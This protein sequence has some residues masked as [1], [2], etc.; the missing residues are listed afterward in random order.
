M[1][2]VHV[3]DVPDEVHLALVRKAEEAGQSLQQ[4]LSAQLAAIATTPT[5]D[6]VLDRVELRPEGELPAD[7][8]AEAQR[9][10]RARR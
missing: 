3:S 4:L 2:Q 7:A 8:A 10:E 6:E 9:E 5:V 1:P